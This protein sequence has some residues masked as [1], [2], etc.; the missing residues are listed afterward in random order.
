MDMCVEGDLIGRLVFELYKDLCPK[1]CANFVALCTGEKGKSPNG[2][3]L[4]Y[5]NSI[6]HRVVPNGWVQGGGK[7]MHSFSIL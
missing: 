1:T 3:R 2:T 5:V 4:S 6:I 7:Y